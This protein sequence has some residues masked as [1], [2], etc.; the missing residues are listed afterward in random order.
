MSCTGAAKN[1]A[2]GQLRAPRQ[3]SKAAAMLSDTGHFT[4]SV[5]AI[6]HV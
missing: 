3:V 6:E 1:I 2:H 4:F 5:A